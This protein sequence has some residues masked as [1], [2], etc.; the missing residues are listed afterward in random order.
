MM[1]L[2]VFELLELPLR[3][4]LLF[5]LLLLLLSRTRTLNK[6]LLLWQRTKFADIGDEKASRSGVACSRRACVI[7]HTGDNG[8]ITKCSSD[9]IWTPQQERKIQLLSPAGAVEEQ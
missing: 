3:G 9:V 7:V 4:F 6:D 8:W 5:F 1:A 2:S